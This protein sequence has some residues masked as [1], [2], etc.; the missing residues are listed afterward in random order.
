[1]KTILGRENQ[2]DIKRYQKILLNQAER[3]DDEEIMKERGKREIARSGA[4]SQNAIS[5][6][7]SVQV[8]MKILEMSGKYNVEVKDMN[9]YLGIYEKKN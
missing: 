5:F 3:L 9:N 6:I 4:L 1:M 8:Q 2:N 7:K